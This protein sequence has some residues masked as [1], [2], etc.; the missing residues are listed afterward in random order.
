MNSFRKFKF[1]V[2]NIHIRTGHLIFLTH[3][4]SCA[5]S[6]DYDCSVIG[7]IHGC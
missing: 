7:L 2:A 5:F 1:N 6:M 4:L 3:L